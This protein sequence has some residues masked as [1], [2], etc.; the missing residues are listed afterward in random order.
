MPHRA[1]RIAVLVAAAGCA[2]GCFTHRCT[3]PAPVV[4]AA[5]GPRL[6]GT[7]QVRYATPAVPARSVQVS[8]GSFLTPDHRV[9]VDADPPTRMLFDRLAASLFDRTVPAPPAE[10]V[11]EVRLD[12]FAVGT[13]WNATVSTVAYHVVLRGAD[14]A[15]RAAFDVEGAASVAPMLRHLAAPSCGAREEAVALAMQDA[16]GAL[17]RKLSESEAVAAWLASRGAAP[18]AF[19]VKRADEYVDPAAAASTSTE[20]ACPTAMPTL[21]ATAASTAT[22]LPT[23]V[24]PVEPGPPP[25]PVAPRSLRIRA[26]AAAFRPRTTAGKLEGASNGLSVTAFGSEARV[27][28]GLRLDIDLDFDTRTYSASHVPHLTGFAPRATLD[29]FT[30][31]VGLRASPPLGSD[32]P[33]LEPWIGVSARVLYTRLVASY[34]GGASGGDAVDTAWSVGADLGAGLNLFVGGPW[35]LGVDVRWRFGRAS[36]APLGSVD[37]GGLLVGGTIGGAMP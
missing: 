36:L 11:A 13:T 24:R 22:P 17:V 34:F 23:P 2:T 30:T 5:P 4:E 26:G 12:R 29:G 33:P 32:R 25:Q 14:G 15:E 37:V 18:V 9:I 6:P 21:T 20:D 1:A 19:R 10:T 16:G 3:V 7:V 28:P 8:P 27:A 35:V 31:G